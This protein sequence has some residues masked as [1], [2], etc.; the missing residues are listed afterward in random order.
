MKLFLAALTI[1]SLPMFG[2]SCGSANVQNTAPAKPVSTSKPAGE[3]VTLTNDHPI[4]SFV[5]KPDVLKNSP[6]IL[7]VAVIKVV[8]PAAKAVTI[9]VHLSPANDKGELSNARIN[10]GNFSLY[11]VDR[12]GKF[13]LDAADALRT[14]AETR[15][16]PDAKGWRLVFELERQAEQTSAPLEV[17][18]ASPNW[19]S[20]KG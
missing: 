9:L 3:T 6:S 8:N 20:D 5:V 14:A 13:M 10:V 18:I 16:P 2:M 11:P 15:M 19:K 4:A 7:E 1:W 12:P 17:T